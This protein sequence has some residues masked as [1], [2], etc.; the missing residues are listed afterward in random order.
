MAWLVWD[1]SDG[2]SI[3]PS[4]AAAPS[5]ASTPLP[6]EL[7]HTHTHTRTHAHTHECVLRSADVLTDR[8]AGRADIERVQLHARPCIN[9]AGCSRTRLDTAA[10]RCQ[11]DTATRNGRVIRNAAAACVHD[12]RA[13]GIALN[14]VTADGTATFRKPAVDADTTEAHLDGRVSLAF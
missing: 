8:F 13:A 9:V 14:C 4:C 6:L 10:A 12:K 1:A 5:A 3:I 7:T 2:G 11:T